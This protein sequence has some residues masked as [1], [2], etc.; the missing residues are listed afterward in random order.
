MNM[1]RRDRLLGV[2]VVLLILVAI[3]AMVSFW[4]SVQAES[5]NFQV[6]EAPFIHSE[7]ADRPVS[8]LSRIRYGAWRVLPE[9]TKS[10][11]LTVYCES[12]LD[13]LDVPQ[14]SDGEPTGSE[15]AAA[16]RALGLEEVAGL[17]ERTVGDGKHPLSESELSACREEITA[18]KSDINACR[19]ACI[20][21]HAETILALYRP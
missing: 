20:D 8:F 10:I 13:G 21:E 18:N 9:A 6:V 17:L 1:S 15:I 5:A 14:V 7:I 4:K 11:W 3:T 12:K 19:Q 16:Y 2:V